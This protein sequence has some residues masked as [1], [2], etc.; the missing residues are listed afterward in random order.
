MILLYIQS[1]LQE[2]DKPS[3]IQSNDPRQWLCNYKAHH[4]L[5]LQCQSQSHLS[6]IHLE[7]LWCQAS[8][9]HRLGQT[10]SWWSPTY[11][12][13]EGNNIVKSEQRSADAWINYKVGVVPWLYV[14]A[15]WFALLSPFYIS[16]VFLFSF[17]SLMWS[18]CVIIGY[19]YLLL[20]LL[21]WCD[22]HDQCRVHQH[23]Q[24]LQLYHQWDHG[25]HDLCSWHWEGFLHW[26]CWR[27]HDHQWGETLLSYW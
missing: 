21:G 26:R 7:Q 13:P 10:H 2:V 12:P 16:L 15:C 17:S 8:H 3:I 5:H 18:P 19:Y 14:L 23:T 9:R 4:P 1:V 20:F 24:P 11:Y 22:H 25:E 27:C 6:S